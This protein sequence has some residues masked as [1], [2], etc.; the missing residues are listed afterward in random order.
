MRSVTWVQS[1]SHPFVNTAD[2]FRERSHTHKSMPHVRPTGIFKP[3]LWILCRRAPRRA[4]P[5]RETRARA[6]PGLGGRIARVSPTRPAVLRAALTQGLHGPAFVPGPG[7]AGPDSEARLVAEGAGSTPRQSGPLPD[8]QVLAPRPEAR[9]FF[10][11]AS[12]VPGKA[13][14]GCG[15]AGLGCGLRPGT[16]SGTGF[17]GRWTPGLGER[18]AEAP[19]ARGAGNRRKRGLAQ[20]RAVAMKPVRPPAH[21]GDGRP[22]VAVVQ[23]DGPDASVPGRRSR[24]G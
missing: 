3:E 21:G 23:V 24:G 8:L 18:G 5:A 17:G 22:G 4:R 11:G 12:A 14:G 7:R 1:K 2:A 13:V 19:K 10:F 9:I 15:L 16:S 20:R 6:P